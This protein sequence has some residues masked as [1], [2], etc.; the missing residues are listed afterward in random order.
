M[1]DGAFLEGKE[2]IANLDE[3]EGVVSVRSFK[4]LIQ[5]LYVGRVIAGKATPGEEI[6]TM[7]EFARLADFCQVDGL[8]ELVAERIKA[9]ILENPA[10]RD[11]S[12][13][14]SRHPDT[15]TYCI[16][17]QAILWGSFLPDDHAVRKILA[18]AVV[19]GYLRSSKKHKF[20]KEA[21]EVLNFANDVMDAV[22]VALGTLKSGEYGLVQFNDPITGMV[23]NA[24]P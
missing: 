5:W 4:L 8:E 1:F 11:Y 13:A 16:T 10:P 9:L 2:D 14:E 19:E 23:L 7:V 12:F 6:E 3:L 15:N 22:K 17:S 20:A 18:M 21:R 24:K